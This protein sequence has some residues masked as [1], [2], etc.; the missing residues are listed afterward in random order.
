[1]SS[2]AYSKFNRNYVQVEKFKEAYEEALHKNPRRGK[3]SLDHFTRA[4]IM[5]LC[6]S[7]E[8]Y[9]ETVLKESCSIVS[10][11][12]SHPGDLPKQVKKTIANH[13]QKSSNELEA[14]IWADN[15]KE[16]YLNLVSSEMDRLNTPK[17][18]NIKSY[19]SK[20]LG[21]NNIFDCNIYPFS[22]VDDVITERGNIAHNVYGTN[23]IKEVKMIEYAD[24]IKDAV[25][26]IDLI[27]YNELPKIIK[28]KPWNNT[29][30]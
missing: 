18:Y 21:L 17:M 27:L 6:S 11:A 23:Y 13:I 20:Y 1:M 30:T 10:K 5:F 29:Y 12:I 15:W 2:K 22:G 7:F 3:R 26:E 4:A 16:Y 19:I 25:K 14:I 28:K 9:Y 24:T 8:V